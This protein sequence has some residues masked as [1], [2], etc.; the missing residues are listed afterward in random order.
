MKK[1]ALAGVCVLCI[2]SAAEAKNVLLLRGMFGEMVAPMTDVGAALQA[3]GH[4]VTYG[5]HRAPPSGKFDMVVTHSAADQHVNKYGQKTVVVSLDPTFLNP[6]CNG[7]TNYYNP[8]NRFPL[9]FC[10]GGYPMRGANNIVVRASHVTVPSATI[11][12]IVAIAGGAKVAVPKTV[13][14]A[15][16]RP[17]PKADE[18]RAPML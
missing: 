6:G 16:P 8:M 13:A 17:A 11:P 10:C 7:C 1:V 5:S 12:Q 2:G 15:P 14:V 4:K 9:I 18:F 3:K